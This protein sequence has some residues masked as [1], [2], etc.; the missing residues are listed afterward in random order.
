MA[1][2]DCSTLSTSNYRALP[3]KS[4]ILQPI[5]VTSTDIGL[6]ATGFEKCAYL[7]PKTASYVISVSLNT[8][9]QAVSTVIFSS[10][11]YAKHSQIIFTP[12]VTL[13]NYVFSFEKKC[14]LLTGFTNL[15]VR[16]FHLLDYFEY[17]SIRAHVGHTQLVS[18]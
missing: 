3:N 1:S 9:K 15:P 17:F 18:K 12:K 2:A 14:S 13:Y 4:T 7:P 6:L 10:I 11:F 5:T 16:D 8:G